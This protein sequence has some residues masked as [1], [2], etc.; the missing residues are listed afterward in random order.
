MDLEELGWNP[1]FQKHF[2]KFRDQGLSPA[3]IAR[4]EKNSYVAYSECGELKGKVS[5]KFKYTAA[6]KSDFPAVGDW[7]AVT[8]HLDAGRMVI[9]GV[10]PRKSTFSRKVASNLSLVTEEQVISANVDTVFLVI[11]LD[12]DFNT[13]RVERYMTLARDSGCR[14][15]IVLNKTDICPAVDEFLKEVERITREMPIHAVSALTKEGLE[16]LRQYVS[17]G[18]T[19]TLVGSSGVGKSTIINA[20]LG[21][22]RQVVG[23]VRERDSKGR[24][25]TAKRELIML[26]GGGMIIDNPGMRSVS[27]WGDENGL[28]QTFEDIRELAMQCKFR[29]CQHR[30]EPGCA[31]K[32]ALEDGTLDKERYQNYLKLQ[33]ELKILAV[34]R[35]QRARVR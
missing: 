31:I 29:G 1:F 25:I 34:R 3:R 8:T 22:E 6:S 19:V 26:P 13:R 11:G 24:H 7:V 4:E 12:A 23:A 21:T 18:Q 28:D 20:L 5:G 27:L 15:V 30:T 17:K 35:E 2:R 33:R 10:L 32:E 9:Q 16:P 14:L